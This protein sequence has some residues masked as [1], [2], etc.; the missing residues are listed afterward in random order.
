MLTKINNLRIIVCNRRCY[1]NINKLFELQNELEKNM[2]II[3]GVEEKALGEENILNIRI[4]ALQVKIGELANLTK[5]YKYTSIQEMNKNKLLFRYV[6]GLRYLLSLGN[7]YHLN[8][9]TEKNLEEV[10]E[11]NLIILFTSIYD[12]ISKLK[13]A[14]EKDLYLMAFNYYIKIFS[15]YNQ[16]KEVLKISQEE[17]YDFFNEISA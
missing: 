7:K 13:V 3:S 14:L 10:E 15:Y 12:M 1:M 11:E 16:I 6:E 8:A 9:I 4:L 17:A 5:C 2:S